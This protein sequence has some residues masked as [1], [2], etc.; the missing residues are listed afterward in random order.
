[1][2]KQAEVEANSISSNKRM[3]SGMCSVVTKTPKPGR[4]QRDLTCVPNTDGKKEHI[5]NAQWGLTS[6]VR[7]RLEFRNGGCAKMAQILHTTQF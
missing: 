4:K 6:V 3:G 7:R 1:M 2:A 5:A